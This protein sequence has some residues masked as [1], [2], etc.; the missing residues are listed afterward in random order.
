MNVNVKPLLLIACQ[1]IIFS[2]LKAQKQSG[3]SSGY[4][5]PPSNKNMLFYLQRTLNKNTVVYEL[6]YNNDST[7]N[8]QE[9]VKAYWIQ[10]SD[11]GQ[12]QPLSGMQKKHSYGVTSTLIDKEKLSFKINLIGYPKRDIYL[13][14]SSSGSYKTYI[15]V[16]AKTVQM[17]RIFFKI[18]GGSLINPNIVYIEITGKDIKTNQGVSERFEP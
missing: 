2:T 1:L 12:R 3:S 18:D 15:N 13:L 5:T 14:K 8:Q 10:Y 9:P 17:E 6:N 7:I 11:K 4:P 16:N